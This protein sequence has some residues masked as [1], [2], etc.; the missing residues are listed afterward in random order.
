MTREEAQL[1]EEHDE[2]QAL[3]KE[4]TDLVKEL[5]SNL[6]NM[7]E[8]SVQKV[9]NKIQKYQTK[10][11]ELR[12]HQRELEPQLK[13]VLSTLE[14]TTNLA[15]ELTKERVDPAGRSVKKIA[16][17]IAGL[18]SRIQAEQQK[19]GHEDPQKI[20]DRF[21]AA[22]KALENQQKLMKASENRIEALK[23][24]IHDRM[25]DFLLFRKEIA[26]ETRTYFNN[27][28]NIQVHHFAL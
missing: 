9:V 20:Q 8:G 13:A 7:M 6:E 12:R 18:E 17:M 2:Q 1:Q 22:Q 5:M 28:M 25:E 3:L 14:Q 24:S 21:F 11:R 10:L 15:L 27:Y 4:K 19:I 26:H 16:A 23:R